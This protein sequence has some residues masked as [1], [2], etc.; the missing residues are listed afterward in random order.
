LC[1]KLEGMPLAIEMAAAWAKTLPPGTMLERLERQLAL[2]ISRRRDLPPRHQSL[3]ATIEWSYALLPDELQNFFAS[4]SVFRGGWTLTVAEA[5]CG[6]GALVLLGSLRSDRSW[7]G[8]SHRDRSAGTRYRLLE[9]LREFAEEKLA[10]SGQG[11]RVRQ[12]HAAY[13]LALAEEAR[14]HM[15]GPDEALWLNRL[16]GEIENLRSALQWCWDTSD[17]TGFASSSQMLLRLATALDRFWQI[18]GYA[19]DRCHWL[20]ASLSKASERTEARAWALCRAGC[21]ARGLGDAERAQRHL[22]E[23]LAIMRERDDQ[24][25]IAEVL[26]GLALVASHRGDLD[27]ARAL[28]EESLAILRTLEDTAG[29]AERLYHLGDLA[30]SCGDLSETRALW[31]ECQAMG[32]AAGVRAGYVLTALAHLAREQGDDAEA[33]RLLAIRLREAHEIGQV[34]ITGT[35]LYELAGLALAMGNLERAARLRGAAATQEEALARRAGSAPARGEPDS[36]VEDEVT[37][38][39]RAALGAERFAAAWA[40]GRA[41]PLEQAVAEVLEGRPGDSGKSGK[42]AL[43]LPMANP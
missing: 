2:L 35:L 4:L 30:R 33:A 12:A 6:M 43:S 8:K 37:T 19:A 39:A 40:Y 41:M 25:G 16:E 18:R 13:F 21:L 9:P 7:F 11:E 17:Q 27:A 29:I 31:E 20:E 38:A 14:S 10:E 34:R 26:M 22:D 3:R 1:H 5:V 15:E 36:G 24:R 23:S 28:H 32:Q 42:S